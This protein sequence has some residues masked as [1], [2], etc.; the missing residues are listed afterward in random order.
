MPR[1]PVLDWSS[2]RIVDAPGISSV[3]D[4]PH[5][6]FTTSGRAAIYQALIQLALPVDA[7]VLVPTYHCPTIVAPVLLAQYDPIFYAVREDGL[8]NLDA[9]APDDRRRAKAI[10]V[11]HFFGITQS[12]REVR[13][14]CDRHQIALIE[15]CAHSFFGEA[16]ER[17]VGAWGDFATASLS[18]FLPVPEAG[19]LGSAVRPV[20]PPVFQK[21]GLRAQ[22]KGTVDVLE[23]SVRHGRLTGLRFA[24]GL[25][26]KIKNARHLPGLPAASGNAQ[27]PVTEEQML[28]DCDMGRISQKPLIA[29]MVLKSVLPRGRIIK[30][31]QRNYAIYAEMLA[32][33]PGARLLKPMPAQPAAPYV[34][35]LWVDDADRVYD[36]LRN[37]GL[38]V[39][40]WDRIWPGTPELPGDVGL[41]WARH[42]LQLLCHQ[43]LTES[44]VR[45]TASA[46]AELLRTPAR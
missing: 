43:D 15:D 18:K 6:R 27:A 9:I 17:P 4:L 22:I 32:A 31:R 37:A 5:Q 20:R 23:Q 19:L 40:R 3:E 11:P 30:Q 38:P 44:D 46:T 24:L 39:F 36:A 26:F 28:L 7:C 12:L 16:G 29:S 2:L 13:D 41:L 21:A 35:P 14:W 10:I 45:H 8:P 33:V 34:F 1:G 42:V 25:L